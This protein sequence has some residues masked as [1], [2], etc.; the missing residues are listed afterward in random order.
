MDQRVLH[1]AVYGVIRAARQ[2]VM[3]P[4]AQPHV[5]FLK[6]SHTMLTI[7][8][9][10]LAVTRHCTL[11]ARGIMN[12]IPKQP[13]Y[14]LASSFFDQQV[15]LQRRMKIAQCAAPPDA[16]HTVN[17]NGQKAPPIETPKLDSIPSRFPAELH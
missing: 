7:K 11:A 17:F 5:L 8:P 4:N 9:R 16:L 13:F 14:I 6:K 10:A 12:V 1:D 2:I 3:Q 15:C